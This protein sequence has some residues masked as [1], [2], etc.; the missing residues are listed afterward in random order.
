MSKYDAMIIII[1]QMRQGIS[2]FPFSFV[3]IN[4]PVRDIL[5]LLSILRVQR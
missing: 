3:L 4:R 1:S 2:I 5:L